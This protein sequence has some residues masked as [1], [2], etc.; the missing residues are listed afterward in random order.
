MRGDQ[1]LVPFLP[2]AFNCPFKR[3]ISLEICNPAFDHKNCVTDV[4]SPTRTG[5]PGGPQQGGLC[6]LDYT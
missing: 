1:G 5:W 3:H 6:M 4:I 2:V